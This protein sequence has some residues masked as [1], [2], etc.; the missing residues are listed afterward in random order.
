MH[1][2]YFLKGNWSSSG[3]L[4]DFCCVLFGVHLWPN[5]SVH[6]TSS[7]TFC[8]VRVR[9]CVHY[10]LAPGPEADGDEGCSCQLKH[11]SSPALSYSL[12]HT[13]LPFDGRHFTSTRHNLTCSGIRQVLCGSSSGRKSGCLATGRLLVRSPGST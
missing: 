8:C 10:L 2:V 4:E 6:Q 12:S 9:A 13:Y 5:R 1:L 11:T 7:P 3:H